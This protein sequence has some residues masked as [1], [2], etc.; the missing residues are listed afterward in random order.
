LKALETVSSKSQLKKNKQ[1]NYL[2]SAFLEEKA[3][4]YPM[5]HDCLSFVSAHF[6]HLQEQMLAELISEKHETNN[7]TC[8][9]AKLVTI[10]SIIYG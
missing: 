1:Q 10:I 9:E 3:H 8:K 6:L 7:C 4:S 2:N 5:E